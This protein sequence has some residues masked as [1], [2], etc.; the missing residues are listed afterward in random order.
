MI[1]PREK[2]P[3]RWSDRVNQQARSS[4][5]ISRRNPKRTQ[6]D[7]S[8]IHCPPS[9]SSQGEPDS[10]VCCDVSGV[11]KPENADYFLRAQA[12]NISES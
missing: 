7:G 11:H 12:G 4:L 5:L 6:H 9:T 2:A 10:D 3:K 8:G 1:N